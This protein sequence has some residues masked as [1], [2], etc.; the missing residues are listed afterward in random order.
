M[1]TKSFAGS[2]FV[3]FCLLSGQA[4]SAESSTGMQDDSSPILQIA[5]SA[6]NLGPVRCDQPV[7]HRF[8]LVNVGS[9]NLTLTIE[10]KSCSCLSQ[11]LS[12]SSIQPHE[13]GVIEVGYSPDQ[14]PTAFGKRTF[15]IVLGTNDV[16]KKSLEL[17]LNAELVRPFE[18]IPRT[19]SLGK[20]DHTSAPVAK[21]KV[22]DYSEFWQ[23]QSNILSWRTT[24][25]R[26]T[27]TRDP[28][29]DAHRCL[30]FDVTLDVRGSDPKIEERLIF[31]TSDLETLRL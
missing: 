21:L 29:S 5:E 13:T 8:K 19:I 7:S 11:V 12:T 28:Q 31:L 20:V 4:G 14:P 9:G 16:N 6:V 25:E 22:V 30:A 18:P 23:R 15:Y 2:I 26:I 3:G 10:K 24:S 1:G 27:L 17:R